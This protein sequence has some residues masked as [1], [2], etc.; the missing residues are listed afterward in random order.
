MN[1]Q[2][3][4]RRNLRADLNPV[5]GSEQDEFRPVLILSH[6]IFNEKSGTVIAL[7]ITSQPKKQDLL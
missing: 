6:D 1:G 2:D 5:I 4:K 7:V 3:I